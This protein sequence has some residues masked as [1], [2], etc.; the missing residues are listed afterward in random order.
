MITDDDATTWAEHAVRQVL[1]MT[2]AQRASMLRRLAE[3]AAFSAAQREV[4][5]ECHWGATTD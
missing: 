4:W 3:Q 1:E 5:N 2:G